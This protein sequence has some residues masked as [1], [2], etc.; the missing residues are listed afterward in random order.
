MTRHSLA[1][2]LQQISKLAV[3][4]KGRSLSDAELLARFVAAS[5]ESAFVALVER[6][7]A[8]VLGVCR[9]ALRH[10]QDAEDACQATFLVLARKA[11][12]VRKRTALSGWLHRVACS[13]C[14][15]VRRQRLRQC[16]HERAVQPARAVDSTAEVS[17][18][19]VQAALDEEIQR[20]PE[21]Y[22]DPLVLCYLD[23]RTHDEAARRLGITPGALRGRL[24]RGR[25]LLRNRL[26]RRGLSLSAALTA[27]LGQGVAR[28]ALSPPLVI[29]SSRAAVLLA[30]G[31]P[32]AAGVLS[33]RAL[34]LSQEVLKSMFLS[35]LKIGVSAVVCAGLLLIAIG[36]A[37]NAEPP[38]GK[39]AP[40][41]ERAK[42]EEAVPAPS[43]RG[44][45]AAAQ[46]AET[47]PVELGELKEYF[48]VVSAKDEKRAFG[49]GTHVILK[50]EV[51]RSV[52]PSRFNKK[53]KVALFDR[54]KTLLVVRDVQF[55]GPIP[56]EKGERIDLVCWDGLGLRGWNRIVIRRA[57][58]EPAQKS[59]PKGQ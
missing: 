16:R 1:G 31:Q 39:R 35:P 55:L 7:G 24:A 50:L 23:E 4:Q 2:V 29:A 15:N 45:A 53:F 43:K 14:A 17:W 51:V 36:A 41:L 56:L 5:D 49:G 27:G 47:P 57:E 21:T 22:R 26:L 48:K 42:Q 33:T 13:I 11:S 44:T 54:E 34:T 9:R 40:A 30:S 12:S 20:L 59:P 32:V 58:A 52:D 38:A 3:V 8:M 37:W 25:R 18:R 6:H 19:E 10:A 46:D 28:A